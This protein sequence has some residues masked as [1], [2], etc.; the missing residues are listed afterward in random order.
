VCLSCLW[1]VAGTPGVGVSGYIVQRSSKSQS[2]QQ[3]VCRV[4]PARLGCN[5]EN[6]ARVVNFGRCAGLFCETYCFGVPVALRFVQVLPVVAHD[7]ILAETPWDSEARRFRG[8][9]KRALVSWVSQVDWKCM[10]DK[11]ISPLQQLRARS[12]VVTTALFLRFGYAPGHFPAAP[13]FEHLPEKPSKRP[14]KGG[15]RQNF[16]FANVTVAQAR[17]PGRFFF[18]CGAGTTRSTTGQKC[19]VQGGPPS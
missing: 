4:S 2:P 7:L 19:D 10:E 17:L 12:S 1:G 9:P 6:Y 14:L 11:S 13:F 18:A 5:G 16:Y 3:F 8:P 15:S